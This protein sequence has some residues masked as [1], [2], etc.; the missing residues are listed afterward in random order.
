MSCPAKGVAMR[1]RASFGI[2]LLTA[3]LLVGFGWQSEVSARQVKNPAKVAAKRAK[4]MNHA[5]VMQTLRG[6]QSLLANADHDYDGQRAKALAEVHK[7]LVELGHKG[8]AA[9]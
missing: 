8:P 1:R 9:P 4:A 2:G 5:E 6:A 7:A 3:A